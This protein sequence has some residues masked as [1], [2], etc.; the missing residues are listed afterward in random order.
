MRVLPGMNSLRMDA[1][2]KK[3]FRKQKQ[4]E[5]SKEDSWLQEISHLLGSNEVH[6]NGNRTIEYRLDRYCYA[7]INRHP[8]AMYRVVEPELTLQEQE[9]IL[10]LKNRL[11]RTVLTSKEGELEKEILALMEKLAID[12]SAISKNRI[13]YYM[14]RDFTSYGFIAPLTRDANI[15]DIS[16]NGVGVPIYVQ[17]R[18][19]GSI[20]TN[21]SFKEESTLDNFVSRLAL[22]CGKSISIAKPILDAGMPEGNRVNITYGREVTPNG[23]TFT[24]RKFKTN[25]I[26]LPEL[27]QEGTI[28]PEMLAYLWTLIEYKSSIMVFGETGSGKTTLLNAFSLFI[29]NELKIVSIQD[30]PEIRL[31]HLNWISAITRSS[32]GGDGVEITMFELLKAALRQRPD[33]MIVGEIRGDEAKALF[34]AV[35]TGQLALSTM[36]ASSSEG[37]ID[38]LTSPPMNIPLSLVSSIGCLCQQVTI[39]SRDGSI[40]RRT[41]S[42]TELI[43]RSDVV[44]HNIVF[45]WNPQTGFE[46]SGKSKQLELIA[47]RLG[48]GKQEIEEEMMQKAAILR[49]MA[50]NNVHNVEEM[51]SNYYENRGSL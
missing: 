48:R 41:G 31:P 44:E 28:S 21:L 19:L 14:L 37:V 40:H 32:L 38:R 10:N 45:K 6:F 42:I 24:I 47:A 51:I 1:I 13:I 2:I 23:S 35:S 34:Q 3:L 26:S 49:Q 4:I 27:I 11:L 39:K 22:R 20:R 18:Y 25:I 33:Y 9:I 46:Y 29:P 5:D 7:S 16:C 36:H 12:V 8:D 50:D 17:H 30:T 43:R 15:E